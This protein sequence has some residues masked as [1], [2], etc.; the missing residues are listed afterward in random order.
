M[1]EN[2]DKLTHEFMSMD[3]TAAFLYD[4]NNDVTMVDHCGPG[5]DCTYLVTYRPRRE[6]IQANK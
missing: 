5:I 6:T 1:C 4:L 2:P 3:R